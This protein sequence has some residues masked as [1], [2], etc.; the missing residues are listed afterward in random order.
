MHMR[1]MDENQQASLFDINTLQN[2]RLF[3]KDNVIRMY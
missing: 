1:N 3:N 2:I